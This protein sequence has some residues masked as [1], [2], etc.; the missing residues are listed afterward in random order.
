[1]QG[2]ISHMDEKEFKRRTKQFAL[3]VIQVV[4][5]LP[6]TKIADQ[7]GGQFCALAHRLVQTIAL[8]VVH[9]LEQT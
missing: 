9:D 5:S 1:M 8:R 7:I 2:Y 3:R 4:Q 6:S